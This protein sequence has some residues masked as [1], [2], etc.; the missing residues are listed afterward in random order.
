MLSRRSLFRRLAAFAAVVALAPEIAFASKLTPQLEL[1]LDELFSQV[2][3]LARMHP[4]PHLIDVWTD[5][6][7]ANKMLR[8]MEQIRQSG[9]VCG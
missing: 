4:K 2:Y 6:A 5:R 9:G 1:N 8:A 3:N 7:T